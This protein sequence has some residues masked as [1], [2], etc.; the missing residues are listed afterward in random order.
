MYE[1]MGHTVSIEIKTGEVYRGIL[2]NVE[3]NMNCLMESVNATSKD[4][5][6]THLQ[7]VYI[8]GSQIRLAIFPDML[9]HAPMF[10]LIAAK[11]RGR[12]GA[13]AAGAGGRGLGTQRRALAMRGARGGGRGRGRG[14]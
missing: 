2:S 7:Q 5:N 10:K 12:G 14:D 13:T 9:R 6:V 11:F 1:G 4:G 8:R 3:D